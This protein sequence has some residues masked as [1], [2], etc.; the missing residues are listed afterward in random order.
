MYDIDYLTKSGLVVYSTLKGVKF[1]DLKTKKLIR[2]SKGI[3]MSLKISPKGNRMITNSYSPYRALRVYD[4]NEMK[5]ISERPS[6]GNSIYS[7]HISPNN[8][9]LYTNC[10]S[11]GFFWDL[12]NFTKHVELKDISGSDSAYI[13]NVFFLNDSEVVV[14][15][16]KTYQNLNLTI[17]NINKK[18]YGKTKIK[19]KFDF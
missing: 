6:M 15:S 9:W 18:K 13:S 8:R 12:T 14:N 3:A 16:G 11:S 5:L 19:T 2:Q 17:Y 1:I 10:M 4:P 7:A